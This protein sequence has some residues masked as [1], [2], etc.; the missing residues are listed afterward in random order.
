[1]AGSGEHWGGLDR[2]G[3][4]LELAGESR[5]HR[6][7]AHEIVLEEDKHYYRFENDD[8]LERLISARLMATMRRQRLVRE[9]RYWEITD[10][11]RDF[12]TERFRQIEMVNWV[13]R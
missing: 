7:D 2:S 13:A 5:G 3:K 9:G 10:R 11:G 12:L 4:G 1:L 6:L 8:A